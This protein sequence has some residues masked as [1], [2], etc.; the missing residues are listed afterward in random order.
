MR[1]LF[2]FLSTLSINLAFTQNNVRVF[3]AKGELFTLTAFDSTQNK[4]PQTNILI[5]SVYED[6]L[7]LKIELENKIKAETTLLLFEKGLPTKNKEFNYKVTVEQNKIKVSYAGY[8]DIVKL[9]QPLVPEKPIVDTTAKYKNTLLGHFCELKDSKPVYFN[10]IPKG[11]SCDLPMPPEYLN[12]TNLLMLKA[13]VA[14]DKFIIADNVCRNNC[15]SVDQLNFILKYIDYELD[16]LKLLKT[17][18]F[19]ITDRTKNKELEKAFR[20][21]SSITELNSFFKV[22]ETQKIKTNSNCTIASSAEEIK[23]LETNLSVYTNDSQRF[24]TFKKIYEDL[25]YSKD[26]ILLILNKFIHDREKLEAAK[27]L[28][29]KCVEKENFL[30]I[31]DVFSYNETVSELKD[32]VA[33]QKD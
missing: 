12:Y 31:S 2:L 5:N 19:N 4:L 1:Y 9:P 22:A 3:S 15:L 32:F 23:N 10:N 16:K 14:E 17:A 7:H 26:Q 27:M 25:C 30:L 6:S 8:Y 29:Y 21:E 28:Y 24:E 33:K 18:Y 11:I 13:Q 20:F